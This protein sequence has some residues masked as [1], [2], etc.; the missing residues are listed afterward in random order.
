MESNELTVA[1]IKKRQEDDAWK[2]DCKGKEVREED[3][4]EEAKSTDNEPANETE[5]KLRGECK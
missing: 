1:E 4:D 2:N 3:D 5:L